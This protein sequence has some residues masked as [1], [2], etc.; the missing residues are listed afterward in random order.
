PA[1]TLREPPRELLAWLRERD[2][3][4]HSAQLRTPGARRQR[5]ADHDRDRRRDSTDE[6]HADRHHAR[7]AEPFDLAY[8]RDAQ[9]FGEHARETERARV[10]DRTDDPGAHR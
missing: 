9:R 2:R 6:L 3:R 8:Q 4:L 10:L 7:I 5:P 1:P